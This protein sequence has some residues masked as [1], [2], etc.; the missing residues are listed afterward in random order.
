MHIYKYFLFT[1]FT[2]VTFFNLSA[3]SKLHAKE[4]KVYSTRNASYLTP[5]FN[6]YSS[7]TGTSISYVVSDTKTL[8]K[9]M[10]AEEASQSADLFIGTGVLNLSLASQKGLLATIDSKTLTRNVPEF[11]RSSEMEW[12]AFATRTEAIVYSP[13][14]VDKQALSSYQSLG[15]EKWKGR[16]CLRSSRTEYTQSLL[17]SLIQRYGA[18]QVRTLVGGWVSNQA[19]K[20]LQDDLDMIKAVDSNVCDVAIINSYYL[21]RYLRDQPNAELKLFWPDQDGAGSQFDI[22]GAAVIE[23]SSKKELAIDFLEWL[24]SK[25]AQAVYA[26]ISMEHPVHKRVYPARPMAKY[27]RFKLDQRPIEDI[28]AFQS[29]AYNLAKSAKYR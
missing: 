21:P 14:R 3:V 18:E 23:S 28:V 20:P 16:L 27:G 29:K 22:T 19:V 4:L 1:L 9:R 17:A 24:T 15:D 25:E 6:R 7:E 12:F 13:E 11:L 2:L 5:L 10:E 26:R 8:M